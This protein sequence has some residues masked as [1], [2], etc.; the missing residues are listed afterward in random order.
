[1]QICCTKLAC[2]AVGVFCKANDDILGANASAIL[3]V[4]TDITESWCESKMISKKGTGW[5]C[6]QGGGHDICA[7]VKRSL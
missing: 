1:M 7:F 4:D 3:D 2:K 6:L 5:L